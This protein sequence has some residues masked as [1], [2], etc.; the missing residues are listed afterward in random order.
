MAINVD[1]AWAK[2]RRLAIAA[3]VL[4]VVWVVGCSASTRIDAGHVGVRIKL[5]GSARGVQDA[6]IAVGWVFY[7][8]LTEQVIQFPTSVQNIVWTASAHEGQPMDESITFSSGEGVNI[9]ADLGLSFHI[10]PTMAP[11]LYGR[12]RQNDLSILANGYMRNTIR[13]AFQEVASKMPVQEIYGAGKSQMLVDVNTKCRDVLGKD[14]IVIDQLT[15]NGTLRLPQNVADAIN[16]AMEA[17]QK[18]I[19]SENRVRQV[20]AEAEQNITQAHGQAEATRQKAQGEADAVLIKARSEAK[21][22][23]IM[24]LSMSPSVLQYRMMQQWDGKLPSYNGGGQIPMLTI[25]ATK[26]AP[27]DEATRE[28][29]LKEMLKEGADAGP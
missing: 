18:A 11:K 20:K 7:N 4:I 27:I 25:D 14:G 21:S 1:A 15:I 2:F 12:F 3:V 10:D 6:E 19:E 17:T 5:A 28:K 22:N 23:E 26:F 8:P 29:K 9:N 13:E 16:R 24:R